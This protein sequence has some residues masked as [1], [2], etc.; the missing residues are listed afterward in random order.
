MKNACFMV[1]LSCLAAL[2]AAFAA[3]RVVSL[4]TPAPVR[5]NIAA[6][7]QIADPRDAAERAINTALHNLDSSV[8]KAADACAGGDWTR[9]VDATMRG[10]GFLSLVI[11]DSYDCE[12]TAHPEASTASI[13]Y[14]LTSGKPVDWARL[15]PKSLAGQQALADEGGSR[16][17]TLASKRLF[18]LYMDGYT[19][20]GATGPELAQC[21]QALTEAGD[22]P[23]ANVW[24]D[25]KSGGLAV[26]IELPHAMAACEDVVVIPNAALRAAGA[27]P[28]LVKALLAAQASSPGLPAQ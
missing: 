2:H 13:V 10:P 3:D 27:Q 4:I 6:L 9:V 7:P 1:G 19:D 12:G 16:F 24:L 26:E 11:T 14:S 20:G 28:E 25:A 17:V 5:G 22:P 23:P 18:A 8:S 21:R 15:L